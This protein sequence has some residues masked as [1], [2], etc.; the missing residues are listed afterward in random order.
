MKSRSSF[1]QPCFQI[2]LLLLAVMAL[3]GGSLRAPFVFDDLNFFES[4]A[5]IANYGHT[6]FSFDLRWLSFAT[7]GWTVNWFGLDIFWLRLGNVLLHAANA[8]TL[9]FL[10]R[11][12]RQNHFG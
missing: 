8:I 1:F 2:A 9:F 10:L 12:N 11:K 5:T 4:P 6:Y 3:Y 7:F